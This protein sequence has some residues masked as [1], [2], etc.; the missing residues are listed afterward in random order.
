MSR[1]MGFEHFAMEFNIFDEVIIHLNF[2]PSHKLFQ[3]TKRLIITYWKA[4]KIGKLCYS[5]APN[6]YKGYNLGD[7][8]NLWDGGGGGGKSM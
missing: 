6:S 4:Y 2:M 3:I 7:C 1:W 5:V 8:P